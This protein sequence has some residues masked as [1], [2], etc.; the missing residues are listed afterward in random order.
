MIL[1]GSARVSKE[2]AAHL[3]PVYRHR[4]PHDGVGQR[5]GQGRQRQRN[6]G[7]DKRSQEKYRDSEPFH[8]DAPSP[9]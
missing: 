8:R 2:K 9:G 1:V 4:K 7:T 3:W 5:Q 6:D